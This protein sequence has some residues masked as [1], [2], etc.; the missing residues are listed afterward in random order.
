MATKEKEKDGDSKKQT[1]KK[2]APAQQAASQEKVY[3]KG[4]VNAKETAAPRLTE[5]DNGTLRLSGNFLEK[6][7]E[8]V[9]AVNF[10]AYNKDAEKIHTALTQEDRNFTLAGHMRNDAL[11]VEN[12]YKHKMMSI[13]GQI[14]HVKENG[15]YTDL[16]VGVKSDKVGNQSFNVSVYKDKELNGAKLEKGET[17]AING[18][19][20]IFDTKEPNKRGVEISAWNVAKDS[21]QLQEIVAAKQASKQEEL[22]QTMN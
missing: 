19:G 10:V 15:Q 12:V 21:N 2:E 14:N 18:E 11:I 4:R 1:A 9:K 17:I 22:A 20:K 8:G 16:L 3:M 13:E 6:T 7:K 5:Y